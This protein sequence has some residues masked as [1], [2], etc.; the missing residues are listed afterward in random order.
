MF[1]LAVYFF[2]LIKRKIK[3]KEKVVCCVLE[4]RRF[5]ELYCFIVFERFFFNGKEICD[6]I[7]IL[8]IFG[9]G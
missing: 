9:V 8:N 3:E 5:I 6:F 2:V 7:C 4:R 1:L